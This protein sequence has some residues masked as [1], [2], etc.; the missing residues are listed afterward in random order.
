[1]AEVRK[2]KSSNRSEGIERKEFYDIFWEYAKKK[3][4][5]RPK[6]FK[7]PRKGY[8]SV[9]EF[10]T[11]R[12]EKAI[13]EIIDLSKTLEV[14]NVATYKIDMRRN[15][16]TVGLGAFANEHTSDKERDDRKMLI[17]A[18]FKRNGQAKGG[19]SFAEHY[20]GT[21]KGLSLEFEEFIRDRKSKEEIVQK[22]VIELLQMDEKLFG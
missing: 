21:I 8:S 6:G 5:K 22:F 19:E 2:I 20:S 17:K 4:V 3:G 10:S 12:L 9:F 15:I 7:T 13:S 14:P 11:E 18:A 16:I 1:M